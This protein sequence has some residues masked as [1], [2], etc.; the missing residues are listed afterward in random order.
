VRALKDA[1]LRHRMGD[2]GFAR[3]NQRFT[4][5]RMVSQ[6]AMVYEQLSTLRSQRSGKSPGSTFNDDAES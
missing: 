1:D 3:V 2:A 6:T 4:V 5:E